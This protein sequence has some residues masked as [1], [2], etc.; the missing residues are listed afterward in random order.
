MVRQCAVW[1]DEVMW[2]RGEATLHHAD[3]CNSAL[4][5]VHCAWHSALLLP[6]ASATCARVSPQVESVAVL[7]HP[8]IVRL[9]GYCLEV[10]EGEDMQEQILAYEYMPNEDM[11][12]FLTSRECG[13]PL[14]ASLLH[15][16][17]VKLV[18]PLPSCHL[19]FLPSQA[20]LSPLQYALIFIVKVCL[21]KRE[22]SF[23]SS[24]LPVFPDAPFR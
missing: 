24:F 13:K 3:G 10:P 16:R 20:A 4:W 19:V 17:E 15:R 2:K 23:L 7:R 1:G 9:Y 6:V 22:R 14:C 5:F 11:A 12:K 8:N 18:V 21:K